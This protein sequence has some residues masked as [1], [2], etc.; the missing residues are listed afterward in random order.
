MLTIYGSGQRI[1][2]GFRSKLFITRVVEITI[3]SLE[4]FRGLTTLYPEEARFQRHLAHSYSVSGKTA[5]AVRCAKTAVELEGTPV[6]ITAL[7]LSQAEDG[8]PD[9]ALATIERAKSTGGDTP[10][11][12][13]LSASARSC[14]PAR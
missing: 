6:N 3:E 9:D 7:A 12:D 11:S 8:H 10:F 5:N 13:G 4:A 2:N 1:A 14:R